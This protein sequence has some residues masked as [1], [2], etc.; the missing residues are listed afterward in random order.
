[1][2]LSDRQSQPFLHTPHNESAP[3]F[4]PDGRWLVYVSNETGR[5][6]IYARPYPG[7]GRERPISTDGGTEPVWNRHGRELFYRN[8]NKMMAVDITTQPSFS[9][10]KP[11]VLFEG[12]Y[13]PSGF[14]FPNYDI[15]PNG[16]Q[17]LML[18][19]SEQPGAAPTQINVVMNWTEELKQKVP[20]GSKK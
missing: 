10:S 2:R 17:F 15:S 4:S 8:G 9:A 20:A 18:K 5:S 1:L 19:G 7:P 11:I 12:Q 13:L 3:Q 6:E 14:D 16:Q